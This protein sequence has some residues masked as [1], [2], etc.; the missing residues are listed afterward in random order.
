MKGEPLMM[1]VHAVSAGSRWLG[2][3]V[4]GAV[5]LT[6]LA[7][8]AAAEDHYYVLRDGRKVPLTKSATE[9]GVVFRS[10]DDVEAARQ[11]IETAGYGVVV[12][13]EEAPNARVKILRVGTSG[14]LTTCIPCVEEAVEEVQPVFRFTGLT[15]PVVS[16]G[17]IV[18][19][20]RPDVT[21]GQR[22][23][24]WQ[25]YGIGRTEDYAGLPNTYLV[26]PGT[27]G[28][29][30]VLLAERLADDSRTLWAN[31]DFRMAA[32]PAQITPSDEYFSYQWHL[33]NTG[34]TGVADADIDA[35][36]AWEIANG[37]GVLFGMYD[38]CCDV[39]HEDLRGS[40]I[41][42]GQDIAWY[43]ADDPLSAMDDPRP[44]RYWDAHGT[45]VMGLAVA[46]GNAVG[47]RGVAHGARF[48]AS[49]GL[50]EYT[51]TSDTASAYD[52]ARQ[53][54][55]DVHINSWGYIGGFPNP[56]VVEEAIDRAFREGRDLDG[57]GGDDPLGMVILFSTGNANVENV[58]G[59]ELSSLPQ[60]IG[61][62]ASTDSDTRSSFSSYGPDM[63]FIAPG[64]GAGSAGIATTDN[65]DGNEYWADGYNQ[66]GF[67]VNPREPWISYGPDI[68]PGGKYTGYFG[69]TSASCP[70]AAG[71]AGLVLSVNPRLTATDVR[72]LMEHTCDRVSPD[73]AR[74]DGITGKSLKYGFGRVN[75]ASAVK[76]A[77]ETLGNGNVTWP[78]VPADISVEG[79]TLNWEVGSGTDEY[80]VVEA[81]GD[82]N[83]VPEDGACY[84]RAQAGC[85]GA[86]LALLPADVITLFVGCDGVCSEGAEQSVDF[87]PP[88][89]GFKLLAVYGRNSL[90]RYSFGGLAAVN[91]VPPPAVTIVASPLQGASPLTVRFNG[92]ALTDVG[93]NPSRTAWDFDVDDNIAVD[94]STPSATYTYIVAAGEA[95]VFRARLTMF[96]T[97][98]NEGSSDVLIRV[99][100][101][102]SNDGRGVPTE[103]QEFR[104]LIG[105]PG[106]P[107]SDITE[108]VAPLSVELRIES[109]FPGSINSVE[110][111]LGDGT[112]AAPGLAV[113]HTYVNES[114]SPQ[115]FPI[116]ATVKMFDSTVLTTVTRLITVHPGVAQVDHGRPDLP[117][118]QPL[119]GTDGTTASCGAFGMIPLLFGMGYLMLLRRRRF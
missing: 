30:E 42:V 74:Y 81:L 99:D 89:V 35:L 87:E 105:V 98:G 114:S 85:S 26:R 57:P 3:F 43:Y 72:I 112:P 34:E 104:I 70:I 36:E 45:A 113:P 37:H 90:G 15:S 80:L 7:G 69:G 93:V 71:V 117:G 25:E 109:D 52:F 53:Q 11:R 44:K 107:G 59:F 13:I 51:S 62:G 20:L 54:G 97:L 50:L 83:F 60:V 84:D 55:V 28:A 41:G 101:G 39:D 116:T 21:S 76:A 33:H 94:A 92:N 32:Q 75:A 86:G 23:A 17:T 24:L 48:T 9:L 4:V 102:V 103:A 64:A 108:G 111:V 118:T 19:R 68:D 40:Y 78:D 46:T 18:L 95:R 27:A 1:L 56:P 100:G 38:D 14:D 79:A 49:R 31:P 5:L 8:E 119:G 65:E 77:Q 61:V 12:D 16:T 66:E 58:A 115:T 63:E 82:F 29:D 96:D 73:D 106:T 47:V 91:A 10:H 110:W 6:A 88:V 2:R 22:Q 67:N